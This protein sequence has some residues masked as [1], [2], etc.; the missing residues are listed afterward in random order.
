[1]THHSSGTEHHIELTETY[2]AHNYHPLPVVLASGEGAWVSDVDGNRFLDCLAGY[3]ALNFGH[4][5]PRLVEVARQQLGTLTLTSR[6]FYNDQL[7]PFAHALSELTGKDMIL[8]MNS[9]A[10]AVETAIKVE[11]PVGLPGQGRAGEPGHDRRHGGQLPRTHHHDRVVLDRPRRDDG[12]RAVHPGLPARAVRRRHGA[13]GGH[14]RHHRR[15]AARAGPGRGRRRH[16]ARGLPPAGAGAVPRAARADGRRRDPVR[17]G[18]HRPHVRVRPRGRRPRH[19]RPRQGARR[20]ALPGVRGG[21]QPR[22]ARRDHA[23]HPRVDLRWQPARRCHRSRGRGDA[24]DRRVPGARGQARRAA[25]RRPGRPGRARHRRGSRARPVGGHRHLAG[26]DDGPRVH[27]GT[28]RQGRAR[29]GGPRPD[30]P[31]RAADRGQRGRHRAARR[32]PSETSSP[33]DPHAESA[34]DDSTWFRCPLCVESAP[35]DSA[36]FRCLSAP[37]RRDFAASLRRLSGG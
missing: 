29:Q 20:G 19:V 11:P 7:G 2:A 3:S 15:G 14:R 24:A 35:D 4:G 16:P 8:P 6:A 5:H 10:E 9:G 31:A 37:T 23:R 22:R 36:R 32:P 26:E 34:P 18:P 28:A 21:R 12:L 27:R 25:V 13:A 17:P 30:R 1:M 33:P